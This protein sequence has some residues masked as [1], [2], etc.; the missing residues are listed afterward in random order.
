LQTHIAQLSP[1]RRGAL[2]ALA[3]SAMNLGVAGA[4]AIVAGVYPAGPA[5]VAAVGAGLIAIAIVA[6]RPDKRD[7]P[8]IP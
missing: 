6:L 3:G 7:C 2:M 1:S 5:W 4:S 8:Q